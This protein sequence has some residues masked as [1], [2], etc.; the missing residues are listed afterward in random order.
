[1]DFSLP[2]K[3]NH[4]R[5]TALVHLMENGASVDDT[6]YKVSKET[7]EASARIL[8][9]LNQNDDSAEE[10]YRKLVQD[11]SYNRRILKKDSQTPQ[12]LILTSR[13][14]HEEIRDRFLPKISRV[15]VEHEEAHIEAFVKL[16]T[17]RAY[18]RDGTVSGI[19]HKILRETAHIVASYP[20][21]GSTPREQYNW[22]AKEAWK[23]DGKPMDRGPFWGE[24]LVQNNLSIHEYVKRHLLK[25]L[26]GTDD[27][28]SVV[29]GFVNGGSSSIAKARTLLSRLEDSFSEGDDLQLALLELTGNTEGVSVVDRTANFA[30]CL[31]FVAGS[32]EEALRMLTLKPA[33]VRER[34]LTYHRERMDLARIVLCSSLPAAL[35]TRIFPRLNTF[36]TDHEKAEYIQGCFEEAPA[37]AFNEVRDLRI[38][39]QTFQIIPPEIAKITELKRLRIIDSNVSYIPDHLSNLTKL[40]ELDLSRNKI[41]ALPE[42]LSRLEN[43]KALDLSSNKISS[44]PANFSS[45]TNLASLEISFNRISSL[46]DSFCELRNLKKLYLNK[47]R[48]TRLPE[49]FGELSQL[50][51]LV[52]AQGRLTSLPESI[53]NL[54]QLKFLNVMGNK[55]GSIPDSFRRLQKLETLD[56]SSNELN[57]LPDSFSGLSELHTLNLSN[58]AI[59]S[60]PETFRSF[61]K[62]RFLS[63][64]NN[65]IGSIP[66]SITTLT[67]LTKIILEN[68]RVS[69]IPLSIRELPKLE[70]LNLIGNGISSIPGP[71]RGLKAIRI[72]ASPLGY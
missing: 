30:R 6:V 40:E 47:N 1:M 27:T 16:M 45:L 23:R 71:L 14:V 48:L 54:S 12:A 29:R 62:L 33:E 43:L 61:P 60:I 63:F 66:D 72:Y 58:N 69:T 44:L 20:G 68:N 55:I 11:V 46:P 10:I 35:Q 34:I 17:E 31:R 49:N 59:S 24:H 26:T 2:K 28:D 25:P 37:S 19:D 56:M 41:T 67:E 9:M 15:K 7:L 18:S 21:S 65:R 3:I 39:H 38:S 13:I 36:T 53:G 64:R 8:D 70:T 5:V 4:E 52:L 32:D 22:L 51:T 50:T 42:S 57:E